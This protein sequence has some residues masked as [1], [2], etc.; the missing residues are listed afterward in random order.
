V[1]LLRTASARILTH[2]NRRSFCARTANDSS[3]RLVILHLLSTS[4]RS[5]VYGSARR[6]GAR[7]F[8]RRRAAWLFLNSKN[9]KRLPVEKVEIL[10]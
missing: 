9:Q 4:A 1:K 6:R 8:A 2:S 7:L 10:L 3:H 5:P